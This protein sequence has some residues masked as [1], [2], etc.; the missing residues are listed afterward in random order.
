MPEYIFDTTVLS[1]FASA[2]R[3]DLLEGRYRGV[4]FTTLEV[5][6]ELR[7][8]IKAG[9]SDLKSAL[10][11]IETIIPADGFA[12]YPRIRRSNTVCSPSSIN[13]SMLVRHL[14]WR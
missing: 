12:C 8:G 11:Q 3:L 4:V 9:Y 7:R 1:N 13:S 5:S 6:N 10:Q 14:V 2:H